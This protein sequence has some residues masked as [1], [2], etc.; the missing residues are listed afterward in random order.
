MLTAS[1]KAMGGRA[2]AWVQALKQN[3]AEAVSCA[4]AA[5][6]GTKDE[7]GDVSPDISL[8]HLLFLLCFATRRCLPGLISHKGTH[9]L[10]TCACRIAHGLSRPSAST[11]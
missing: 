8:A 2:H 7:F 9:S 5:L 1:L 3:G 4:Q 11:R 10:C 6:E